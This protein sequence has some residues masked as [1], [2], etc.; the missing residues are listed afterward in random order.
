MSHQASDFRTDL[1]YENVLSVTH[2]VLPLNLCIFLLPSH[3]I[4]ILIWSLTTSS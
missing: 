4:V 1:K 2:Y 3:V